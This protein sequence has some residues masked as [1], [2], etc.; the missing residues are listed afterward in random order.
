MKQLSNLQ[1]YLFLFLLLRLSFLSFSQ[2]RS[3]DLQKT[4]KHLGITDGLPNRQIN[5]AFIDSHK[6]IWFLTDNKIG[7][8]QYGKI[9]NYQLSE[10]FSNRG[11]NSA[12][13]D[14]NGNFWISEN[15]EW[16]YPF[17]V[18]HCLIFN[19]VSHKTIPVEN[20]IHQKIA[21]HS[22]VSDAQNQIFIGTKDGQV[23]RFDANKKTLQLIS[24]FSKTPI[25]LL[26]ASKRGLF[27]CLEKNA[28]KDNKLIQLNYEGQIISQKDLKGA[29]VRSMFE[30]ENQLLYVT[31]STQKI[32]LNEFGGSFS[33]AFTT[34]NYDYLSNITHAKFNKMVVFND[35]K[36]INFYDKNFH[37]I[38]KENY[39]CEI[40][41]IV[42]DIDG[43]FILSTNNGVMIMQLGKKKIRT[44]LKNN[45][46]E[47]LNDNF[48]CRKILKIDNY[49]IIVNTNKKRQ[50]INLKTGVIKNL[51]DFKNDEESNPHFVLSSL[52][53]KN[54]DLL[55]GEDALIRTN[56]HTSKDEVLCSF[57]KVKIWAICEFR[58]GY[59]LG[60]ERKG[61]IYYD[62]KTKKVSP[63]L[64]T[65]NPFENSIIY[66]FFVIG[67]DV[68]VASEA[69]FYQLSNDSV[70]KNHKFPLEEDRQMTCFSIQKNKKNSQQLLLATLNGIW[71][72]DLQKHRILPFLKEEKYD[73][74]KYLSAYY[75][76]NGVW[77]STEEGIWHFDDNGNLMKIYTVTDGLT[78]NECNRLA[79]FQDENDVLYF[80]GINGLNILNPS[81]FSA[82]IEKKFTLKMDSLFTYQDTTQKRI[83]SNYK[84][85]LLQLNR[86]ENTLKL[87]FSFEDFKY[88]CDKKYYYRTD[89]LL[90]K[91]W[92]ELIDRR[93]LISNVDYGTTTVEVMVV[94]CDDF[95]NADVKK[96]T[97]N[98]PNP[99]YLTWYFWVTV[100]IF[101]SLLTWGII[102]YST[103]QLKRRN[104][105]L[106]QKVDAQ[107]ISLQESLNLK[108]TLLSLLIHDVRYPVQSFYGITKKMAY[109][110]QKNDL[111]RLFLLGTETENK[112][113]KVLWLID[114]MVYWVKGTNAN[115]KINQKECNLGELIQQ[116]FEIYD[117]ELQK[118]KLTYT[119]T[120][121]DTY[122]HIEQG[123]FVIIM[124]NLIFN[125]VIHSKVQTEISVV[126]ESKNDNCRIIIANEFGNTPEGIKKG[127]GI[128]MTLLLPI[129]EKANFKIESS[130]TDNIFTSKLL[131]KG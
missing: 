32:K 68:Y 84:N 62:K 44:F 49:Q 112:S 113:R 40:H 121:A 87:T 81:D 115:F 116:I 1:K 36:S 104:E 54:G 56:I 61:I 60:L 72:Y 29:F 21:I 93:L 85:Q 117:E 37:L 3:I 19:P 102:K 45:E 108:E 107:T 25:K 11:F 98:R 82:K 4:E 124:R 67:N 71:I 90:T 9:N 110:I 28:R 119:L 77:A 15:F 99:L 5:H 76:K 63:F 109:L 13:E 41:D 18:Q 48:S 131:I 58:D 74:K 20:Y 111:E 103:Y 35:G 6:K 66:D 120:N 88:N 106:Q 95:L 64:K 39:D 2:L 47:K 69:G 52:K 59:L 51:H 91:E 73:R 26:Y 127:L 33:K 100:V 86:G 10:T 105:I 16:Y 38:L 34:S 101:I 70:M 80:G 43:N 50:L 31:L 7:I 30:F 27:G 17:N 83:F 22:I 8:F 97:I 125:A 118:K 14:A 57:D 65:K 46:P 55:F 89:K 123:L 114:E 92:Q 79:H 128:G 129:L 130:Q 12:N 75:T 42:Q 122:V 94:S 126:L 23:F 96:I 24:T 78:S 53:D